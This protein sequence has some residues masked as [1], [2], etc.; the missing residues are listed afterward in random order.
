[1][2]TSPCKPCNGAGSMRGARGATTVCSAC[3]GRGYIHGT[4]GG[5]TPAPGEPLR[6]PADGGKQGP[7]ERK[8]RP[9]PKKD[10]F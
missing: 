4:D 8:N 9:V 5:E 10:R 7:S 2:G 1:M 3:N 6:A